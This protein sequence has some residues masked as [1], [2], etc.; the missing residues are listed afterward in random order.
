LDR[1]VIF[2]KS[3]EGYA[4]GIVVVP[5]NSNIEP[6]LIVIDLASPLFEINLLHAKL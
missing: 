6:L 5:V 1:F 3:Q 2:D 4:E